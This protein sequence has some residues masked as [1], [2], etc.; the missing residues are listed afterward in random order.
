MTDTR[1]GKVHEH[2]LPQKSCSERKNI[3]Q[4]KR[5]MFSWYFLLARRVYL[6][7]LDEWPIDQPYSSELRPG[8]AVHS[9]PLYL[10]VQDVTLSEQNGDDTGNQP[11]CTPHSLVKQ[12][13][14]A[15]RDPDAAENQFSRRACNKAQLHR[16]VHCP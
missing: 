14:K 12:A 9:T 2:S 6:L 11:P 3:F 8:R 10:Y 5:W 4:T 7:F 15:R 16:L 1:R 13:A